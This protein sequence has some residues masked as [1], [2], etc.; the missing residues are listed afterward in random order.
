MPPVGSDA[1]P[2]LGTLIIGI[3][4]LDAIYERMIRAERRAEVVEAEL[5]SMRVEARYMLGQLAELRRQLE[6]QHGRGAVDP[7]SKP[8]AR[9]TSKPPGLVPFDQAPGPSAPPTRATPTDVSRTRTGPDTSTAT[10]REAP[11]ALVSASPPHQRVETPVAATP[12]TYRASPAAPGRSEVDALTDQLRRVYARLDDYRR[13]PT[14]S[15]AHEVQRQR[16]LAEYDRA[17]VRLCGALG[18]ET[19][20]E[21]GAPVSVDARAALTRALAHAGFDVRAPSGP[22]LRPR[23]AP[24]SRS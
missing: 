2:P 8:P 20:L 4:D 10:V 13:K 5:Q 3:E 21:P 15:P 16:E 6:S 9:P 19:G 1:A 11:S 12:A 23:A 14:I 7:T 17:L 24:R 18:M 22:P